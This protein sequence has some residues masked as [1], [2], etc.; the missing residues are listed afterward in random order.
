MAAGY[1]AEKVLKSVNLTWSKRK[2]RYETNYAL[3]YTGDS[4]G[5]DSGSPLFYKNESGF[6]ILGILHSGPCKGCLI[7]FAILNL[8]KYFINT[9]IQLTESYDSD[10]NQTVI[11][12]N[13]LNICSWT[14]TSATSTACTELTTPTELNETSVFSTLPTPAISSSNSATTVMSLWVGLMV[15]GSLSYVLQR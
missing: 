6:Y 5:G 7:K 2:K 8:N 3:S 14:E 12:G 1:A 10:K 13:S 9:H 11:S 4:Q 15:S